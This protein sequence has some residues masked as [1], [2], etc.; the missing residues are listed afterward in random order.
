VRLF[1]QS[2]PFSSKFLFV[3]NWKEYFRDSLISR[4]LILQIWIPFSFPYQAKYL[5]LVGEKIF[6]PEQKSWQQWY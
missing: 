5:F 3:K 1:V 2:P 6:S 4:V